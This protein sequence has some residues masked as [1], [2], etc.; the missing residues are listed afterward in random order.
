MSNHLKNT[1][2]K[3]RKTTRRNNMD[4]LKSLMDKKQYELVLKIT[5]NSQDSLSLF[6]RLSALLAVNR[7][8][9][10]LALIKDKRSILIA[11]PAILMK[12]HIEILCLLGRFDEAYEELNYYKELP[13][14]N[15]QTEELLNY[16]PKYIREE[17]KKLFKRQEVGQEEI[18]K[19]LLSKNDNDVLTALNAV[20]EY[21]LNSFLLPILN[22]LKTY[23]KQMIRS[24]ALLLLTAKSYDKVVPFLSQ[25]KLIE[26]KPSE[27]K[28]PFVLEGIGDI[29]AISQLFQ[30]AY[31]NPSLVQN[32]VNILSS[33]L[34]YIYP[35][36][37]S[38]NENQLIVV[39]G[40]LAQDLLQ[41][42][43]VDL[44]K[45]CAERQ[46]DKEETL[47]EINK[48]KDLLQDF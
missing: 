28:D 47:K 24:Y 39:F 9:D 5:E 19:K 16:L 4:S 38:F 2:I 42:K 26:V 3:S 36:K 45:L 17:E 41:I 11:K 20:R 15:Q 12:I 34:I 31:H 7:I 21:D 18:R 33:Y 10:A 6:Y 22:I 23:P 40:Y 1:G 46:L 14:E 27:L 13:Y 25:D 30:N 29:E 37:V 35:N 43:D 8:N 32:A 48:I 44:D